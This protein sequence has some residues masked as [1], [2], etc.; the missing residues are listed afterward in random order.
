[1][2]DLREVTAEGVDHVM[3]NFARHYLDE[4]LV[5]SHVA[6]GSYVIRE[7]DIRYQRAL[8]ESVSQVICDEEHIDRRA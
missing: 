6:A 8:I 7:E 5:K 2:E 4:T 1:M 3:R